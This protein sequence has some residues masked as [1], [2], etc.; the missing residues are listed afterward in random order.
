MKR[1]LTIITFIV[2]VGLVST[3]TLVIAQSSASQPD[4]PVPQAQTEP[5]SMPSCPMMKG[6]MHHMSMENRMGQMDSMPCPMMKEH[7]PMAGQCMQ[8][9]MSEE[10]HRQAMIEMLRQNPQL[11]EQMQ[12]MLQQAEQ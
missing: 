1:T 11:R 4:H 5:S 10:T 3:V 9:M 12:Q 2:A 6:M 7:S 8:M